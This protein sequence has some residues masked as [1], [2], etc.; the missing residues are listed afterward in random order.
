G[1]MRDKPF[2][3][4]YPGEFQRTADAGSELFL[5]HPRALFQVSL[6]ITPAAEGASAQL[7]ARGPAM[8]VAA[9]DRA[10]FADFSLEQRSLVVLP[11]GPAHLYAATMT[12]PMGNR[13]RLRMV[14]AEV[15]SEGRR[16]ELSFTMADDVFASAGT[17][18][19]F[20]LANFAPTSA[21]RECCAEPV[22]LPW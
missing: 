4:S 22:A 6:K 3:L 7:A 2:S 20:M 11:A 15:F 21:V 9:A 18:I 13:P 10:A 19:G 12:S 1:L 17:A 16:C 14:V 5:D 8:Q